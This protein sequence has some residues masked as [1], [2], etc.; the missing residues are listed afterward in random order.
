MEHVKNSPIV[1]ALVPNTHTAMKTKNERTNKQTNKKNARCYYPHPLSSFMA[2]YHL[3]PEY[4]CWEHSFLIHSFESKD[5][6]SVIVSQL[7]LKAQRK[8]Q[9][10]TQ[11]KSRPGK[12]DLVDQTRGW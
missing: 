3:L 6:I 10:A 1:L 9:E 5:R 4:A 2:F 7:C 8:M 11:G 12:T